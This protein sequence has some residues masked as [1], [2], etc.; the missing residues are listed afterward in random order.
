VPDTNASSGQ[1]WVLH[2]I[3]ALLSVGIGIVC[4]MVVSELSNT[5]LREN[6]DTDRASLEQQ[7]EASR[8]EIAKL[9]SQRQEQQQE[10]ERVREQSAAIERVSKD[11]I[12]AARVA[13]LEDQLVRLTE[14]N[15][16]LRQSLTQFDDANIAPSSSEPRVT[17]NSPRRFASGRQE[18]LTI[19]N[20][21]IKNEGFGL[22]TVIGEVTNNSTRQYSATLMATF[23]TKEGKILGT[24]SGAINGVE[25]GQTKTFQL[26]STDDLENAANYKVAVDTLLPL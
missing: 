10:I 1:N 16:T 17:D 13:R 6:V 3:V 7:M 20:T 2:A 18:E 12:N 19:T 21:A 4:G 5:R 22:T 8:R 9:N 14:E 25:A 23:Y 24:A 11:G 26:V 15:E